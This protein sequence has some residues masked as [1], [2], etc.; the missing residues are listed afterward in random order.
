MEELLSNNDFSYITVKM[1]CE[2]AMIN[3][4][5]FYSYYTDKYSLVETMLDLEK[6]AYISDWNKQLIMNKSKADDDLY[7]Y[8]Y[9][10]VKSRFPRIKL[11]R[12]CLKKDFVDVL[13]E[14]VSTQVDNRFKTLGIDDNDLVAKYIYTWYV[15][16]YLK[17]MLD[18]GFINFNDYFNKQS[19]ISTLHNSAIKK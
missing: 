4:K 1:I 5:T 8:V 16:G 2:K 19:E 7:S 15:V 11:Y 13:F 18:Y 9:Q 14:I 10:A 12:K 6:E 3:R 17:Y